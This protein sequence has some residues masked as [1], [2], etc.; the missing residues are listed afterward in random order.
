[1]GEQAK[2]KRMLKILLSMAGPR[3]YSKEE[4]SLRNNLSVK[5]IGR[6]LDTFES[7]GFAIEKTKYRYRIISYPPPFKQ[8]S[9]LLYFTEEEAYIL[10][11]AIHSIDETNLLKQHLAEKLYAL[12][13]FGKVAETIV[14]KAHS[15]TVSLLHGAI[16]NKQ[17]VLLRS[18]RS[19][20]GDMV[21]DRLV[22]PFEF[23][24]NFIS[25]WAF[26]PE[27]RK[28]KLFKTARIGK[29]SLTGKPAEYTDLHR[30]AP[31]DVFRISSE[32]TIPVVLE[33]NLRA[34]NLLTEEYPLSAKYIEQKEDNLWLFSAHV[35]GY[36]GV[37]RFVMGLPGNVKILQPRGLKEYVRS[38]IK[39]LQE[40][41]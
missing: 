26:D 38:E 15:K 18:Y 19:A 8:L 40:K 6:Y 32:K 7:V 35:C 12:Y 17:Q 29:V 28:N 11:T 22:E 10:T 21:R 9:D 31:M 23:T 33:L 39:K 24:A 36:E 13:H 4:L 16:E 25:I 14:N 37:G 41:L 20:H 30:S 3:N 2:F 27:S 34:F 1:M 5:T